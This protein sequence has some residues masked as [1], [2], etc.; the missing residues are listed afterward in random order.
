MPPCFTYGQQTKYTKT[1]AVGIHLE[2]LSFKKA[3]TSS[4]LEGTPQL[5]VGIQYQNNISSHIV[6]TSAL[7][8][9]FIEQAQRK[10][11][12]KDLFLEAN[13]SLRANC[14]KQDKIFNPYVLMGAGLSKYK[15]SYNLS[16]PAGIGCQINLSANVFL[17]I[18]SQ[19]RFAFTDRQ[20]NHWVNSIGIAGAINR[21]KVSKIKQASIPVTTITSPI[22]SDGDG[23]ID[24]EDSCRLVVGVIKYHGCPPPDRD[25]DGVE[26]SLDKCPD[27]AGNA[28]NGGCPEVTAEI[29]QQINGTATRIF[30]ETGSFKL[31][32]QS[33][34][35]LNELA[36][37]LKEN[38]QIHL[39]IEGHTDNAGTPASNQL[40]SE[41]RARTVF[42]YLTGV[43]IS[44]NR[45]QY[46]GFGQDRPIS[47]NATVEG[48][49]KNRRVE[50]KVL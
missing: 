19:Y 12:K 31:L 48:R 13:L 21:K 42:I 45:L 37:I 34:G 11:G 23:I 36:Q 6:F 16:T 15:D 40:L 41:N 2:L 38:P 44:N 28:R 46:R 4:F 5:G 14:F 33:H 30:F 20:Y 50:L 35:P 27:N 29:K 17:L 22:D 8:G 25:Q 7:S 47:D 43:G 26:D 1:P 39:L 3:D 18:N 10:D 49:A 9:A 24:N 32:Q